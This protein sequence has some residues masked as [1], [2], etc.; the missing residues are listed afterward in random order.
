MRLCSPSPPPRCRGEEWFLAQNLPL[1]DFPLIRG[2]CAFWKEKICLMIGFPRNSPSRQ[3]L[4]AA[5]CLFTGPSCWAQPPL[6]PFVQKLGEKNR[7][8]EKENEV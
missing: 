4:Y 6:F 2:L 5:S 3:F 1:T 8:K 7:T